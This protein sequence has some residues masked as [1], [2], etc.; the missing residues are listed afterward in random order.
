MNP[1]KDLN[2]ELS[3]FESSLGELRVGRRLQQ[4]TSSI[5]SFLD[6]QLAKLEKAL[7]QCKNAELQNEVLQRIIAEFEQQ[8][9][10]WEQTRVAEEKRLFAAGEKL[11]EGWKQLEQERANWKSAPNSKSVGAVR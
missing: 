3:N 11:I 7:V 5:G 10:D 2:H 1:T 6:S 9:I 4:V 8:K